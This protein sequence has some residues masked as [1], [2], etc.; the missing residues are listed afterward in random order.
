MVSLQYNCY[1]DIDEKWY[2][3]RVFEGRVRVRDKRLNPHSFRNWALPPLQKGFRRTGHKYEQSQD[4]LELAFS[5]TDQ[6]EYASPPFPAVKW[7]GD[8]ITSAKVMASKWEQVIRL[9]LEGDKNTPM[10]DLA[11]VGL[12]VIAAKLNLKERIE[13]NKLFIQW[14]SIKETFH[15]NRIDLSMSVWQAV[16][17]DSHEMDGLKY[18]FASKDL[19]KFLNELE[20][21]LLVGVREGQLTPGNPMASAATKYDRNKYRVPMIS[22][23]LATAFNQALHAFCTIPTGFPTD[24]PPKTSKPPKPTKPVEDDDET[25]DLMP[26]PLPPFKPKTSDTNTANMYLDYDAAGETSDKSGVFRLPVAKLIGSG[27]DDTSKKITLF[28]PQ[29]RRTLR[30]VGERLGRHPEMPFP[31]EFTDTKTSIKHTL[32]SHK[33]ED[34][35]PKLMMDGVTKSFRV[36][37]I[38]VYALSRAPR[39][40]EKRRG[41]SLPYDSYLIGDDDTTVSPDSGDVPYYI[42]PTHPRAI[43]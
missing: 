34:E 7:S 10:R 13:G 23:G 41:L 9:S 37:M 35:P 30:I 36:R 22:A 12:Q 33:Q 6:E 21:P 1:D 8:L 31:M 20:P 25:V 32:I 38:L 4:G 14:S 11:Q 42:E 15:E 29:C 16:G 2:T 5:F 26:G 3:K 19:G 40:E 24:K 28:L 17:K 18:G 39:A 27:Q 43:V